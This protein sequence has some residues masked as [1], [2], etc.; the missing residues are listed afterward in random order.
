MLLQAPQ[1]QELPPIVW[2]GTTVQQGGGAQRAGTAYDA[3][4]SRAI[5]REIINMGSSL[6]WVLRH[7]G[8]KETGDVNVYFCAFVL[9]MQGEMDLSVAKYL[10]DIPEVAA[11]VIDCLPEMTAG[12]QLSRCPPRYAACAA[13]QCLFVT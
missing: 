2:F 8:R 11:F 7:V 13:A 10:A 9:G 3:I 6:C 5:G 12:K 1:F 4:V